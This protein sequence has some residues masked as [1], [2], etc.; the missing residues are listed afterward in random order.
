MPTS[1]MKNKEVDHDKNDVNINDFS[2]LKW[3]TKRKNLKKR[4]FKC[5]K[6][7]SK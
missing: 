4:I 1:N 3:V 6:N 7:Q 5:Q 2:S